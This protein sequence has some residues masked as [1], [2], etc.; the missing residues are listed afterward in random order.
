MHCLTC[1]PSY[2]NLSYMSEKFNCWVCGRKDRVRGAFVR[3]TK[4]LMVGYA[5]K[6]C[7]SEECQKKAKK[8]EFDA[9][10]NGRVK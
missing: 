5:I 8:G 2:G 3:I 7:R 4:G 1:K 6:V 10:V 9:Y